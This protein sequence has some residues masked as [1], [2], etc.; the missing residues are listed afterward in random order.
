MP[1]FSGSKHAYTSLPGLEY[2]L[3]RAVDASC[4]RN[5]TASVSALIDGRL[6][7]VWHKYLA[8]ER[9]TSDL[10]TRKI[11]SR[12]RPTAVALGA[13]SEFSCG[14]IWPKT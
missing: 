2:S 12:L 10:G 11:A 14:R 9:G 1:E 5:D 6:M 7:V 3:V 13:T 8:N 4:P